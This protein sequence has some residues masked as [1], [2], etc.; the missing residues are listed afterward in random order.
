MNLF[1]NQK[2]TIFITLFA[3]VFLYLYDLGNV[4]A[5]RQGTESLYLNITH[6]MYQKNSWL[7]PYNKGLITWTKPPAHFW[8][9]FPMHF[10]FGGPS[11]L[12]S[13]LSV[14]VLALMFSIY[15]AYWF[16]KNFTINW[17]STFIF[18]SS[19]IFMIRYSRIYMMEMTMT[20]LSAL[21]LLKYFDFYK[22]KKSSDLVFSSILAAFANLV[23]GPITL[24]L[25]F[26]TIFIFHLIKKEKH[27]LKN[28]IKFVVLSLVLGSLWY[29]ASYLTFGQAFINEFFLKENLGKFSS[30]SYS[31]LVLVE[32][33]VVNLLPWTLFAIPSLVLFKRQKTDLGLFLLIGFSLFFGIWFIP[34]QRSHHYAIPSIPYLLLFIWYKLHS[35]FID[36]NNHFKYFK[37]IKNINLIFP[38]FFSLLILFF[39]WMIP[40]LMLLKII[41]AISLLFYLFAVCKNLH[42]NIVTTLL[43]INLTGLWYVAI[44]KLYFPLIPDD[45][46]ELIRSKTLKLCVLR[47]Y[48][49]QSLIGTDKVPVAHDG[50][51]SWLV[52]VDHHIIVSSSDFVSFGVHKYGQIIE[53]WPKWIKKPSNELIKK[54]II[55]G[56]IELLTEEYFLVKYKN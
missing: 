19:S 6:E 24:V 34:K 51:Q 43:F 33:L 1:K 15:I 41:L 4:G 8:M 38:M 12:T 45:K 28:Y 53:R 48:F 26:G 5:I 17:L 31:P 3:F 52:G 32:G 20:A 44:P 25:E 35:F 30:M 9:A 42:F 55:E 54:S 49:F 10:L 40:G 16:K 37:L 23:K 39:I 56:K 36:H 47:P 2:L 29:G 21:S 11:I 14:V 50:I 18:F 46:V 7:A 13:R 27:E 22:Q